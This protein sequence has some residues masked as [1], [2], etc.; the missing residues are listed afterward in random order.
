[1][2][3]ADNKVRC[4]AA[5]VVVIYRIKYFSLNMILYDQAIRLDNTSKRMHSKLLILEIFS[6]NSLPKRL[7]VPRAAKRNVSLSKLTSKYIYLVK[8]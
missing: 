7:L 6:I 1:M 2:S 5:A 3:W 8:M 4:G